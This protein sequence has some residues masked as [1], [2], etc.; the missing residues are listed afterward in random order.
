MCRDACGVWLYSPKG[1]IYRGRTGSIVTEC[2]VGQG[3]REAGRA[4][5]HLV[6]TTGWWF[7]VWLADGETSFI[8]IDICTPPVLIDDEWR[9]TDLEL[10]PVAYADGRFELQDR[11]E[12]VAAC[13]AGVITPAEAAEARAAADVL[14]GYLK[15]G[16]EPFG[17]VGWERLRRALA[18][19]LPPITILNDEPTNQ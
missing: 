9:Y 10:D 19:G 14:E 12:F 11:E 18:S 3:D 13:G 5:M 16:V 15:G 7:A 6:P 17:T 2:E 8:A 1:T 4:V